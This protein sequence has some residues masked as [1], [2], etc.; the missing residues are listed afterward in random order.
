MDSVG[1]DMFARVGRL[2]DRVQCLE[3]HLQADRKNAPDTTELMTALH[4][5]AYGLHKPN[6]SP[7]TI[8]RK[9]KAIARV[10]LHKDG[11]V[12]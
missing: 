12:S 3:N 9:L 7:I 4:S 8:L 11:W 2:E 6:E 1:K 10:A 5:I